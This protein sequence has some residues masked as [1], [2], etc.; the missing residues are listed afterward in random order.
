MIRKAETFAMTAL[1]VAVYCS[2]ALGQAL[3]PTILVIEVENQVEYQEDLSDPSRI[4]TNPGIT[5]PGPIRRGGVAVVY[6]DIVAVNGQPAKGTLVARAG[7]IFA[8]NPAPSPGQAIADIARGGTMREQIFAILKSDGTPIGTIVGL[9]FSGGPPPAGAPLIQT[10]GNWPIV[11]GTGPFLGARGQFGAAQAAGDPPPR[12]ASYAE[13]PANRR[14]NGGGKQRYVLTVIPMFRPEIVQTP[15]GPAVTHS[16]DFSL[17]TASKPAAA[18]EVLSLFATG[19]GPTRPGVNPSAPF[20]ASPPAVVN[21]PVEV[22]VNGRPAEVTAAVGF[23]GAVDGYQVNFRVPPDTAKGAAT[24]QV[25]AA[26]IA[27][28]E[29]KMAIQ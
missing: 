1:L 26:W 22:T 13:D 16:S 12:A 25:S 18:G 3:P 7:G 5:P 17:V 23:P 4:G 28:P 29:V 27:G 15:S 14:I 2:L 21:S 10:S 9:G 19:L 8:P 24:V 6:G 11:G 20:P